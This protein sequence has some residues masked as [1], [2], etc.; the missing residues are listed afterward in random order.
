M[1]EKKWTDAKQKAT[2]DA[3]KVADAVQDTTLK[4]LRQDVLAEAKAWKLANNAL[5]NLI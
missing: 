5:V 1:A 4:A 3:Q 2:D